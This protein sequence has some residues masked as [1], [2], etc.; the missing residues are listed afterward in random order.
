MRRY[1]VRK[2]LL[3]ENNKLIY[4]EQLSTQP[5]VWNGSILLTIATLLFLYGAC[6]ITSAILS[7]AIPTRNA[8]FYACLKADLIILIQ[9]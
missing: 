3:L 1:L 4:N 7:L 9:C 6:L 2:F 8:T 5:A